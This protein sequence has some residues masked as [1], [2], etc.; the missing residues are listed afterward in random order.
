MTQFSPE[1]MS[2]LRPGAQQYIIPG[3]WSTI[4]DFCMEDLAFAESPFSKEMLASVFTLSNDLCW[5]QPV[6]P[7]SGKPIQ[8]MVAW[9]TAPGCNYNYEYAQLSFEPC[10]FPEWFIQF[11]NEVF[12]HAGV[13]EFNFNCCNVNWYADG[14]HFV[15]W[16]ADD[17]Y[18]FG[19]KQGHDVPI[20]SLSIGDSREF[21]LR[22]RNTKV[23][24]PVT[25]N[26]GDLLFMGRRLQLSHQHKVPPSKSSRPR[27]N[28]T[29]RH[30]LAESELQAD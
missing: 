14:R 2:S 17:E 29:W 5:Q 26:S 24:T 16:H 15:D 23:I 25:L 10:S 4:S 20:L 22:D 19:A 1:N 3:Q 27:L 28:F 21:L 30:M 8:R 11:Q 13:E 9:L 7:A 6:S 18:L 12:K